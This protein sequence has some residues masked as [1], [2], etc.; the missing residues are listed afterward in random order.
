MTFGEAQTYVSRALQDT[1]ADRLWSTTLVAALINQGC[2]DVARRTGFTKRWVSFVT[3]PAEAGAN[4]YVPDLGY[5]LDE[6]FHLQT[7]KGPLCHTTIEELM[8]RDDDWLTQT[9]P[10][11]TD[12]ALG[13]KLGSVLLYPHP[14]AGLTTLAGLVTTIYP[15]HTVDADTLQL[16]SAYHVLP[17]YFAIAEAFETDNEAQAAQKADRWRIKYEKGLSEMT[18]QVQRAWQ[19]SRPTSEPSYL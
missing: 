18:V 4:L 9:G 14:S 12:Y 3:D 13:Y 19:R 7:D 6:V 16:P 2:Q 8:A 11:P 1:G 10:D 15:T 17:C 5:V